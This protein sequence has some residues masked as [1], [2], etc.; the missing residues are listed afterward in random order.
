MVSAAATTS[1]SKAKTKGELAPP[2][3]QHQARCQGERRDHLEDD[4]GPAAPARRQH[5]VQ[6]DH[7]HH[8]DCRRGHRWL[9]RF[10]ANVLEM[11]IPTST[12]AM[13]THHTT[14]TT[15]SW[16][17]VIGSVPAGW[18]S[19]EALGAEAGLVQLAPSSE[20]RHQ[21]TQADECSKPAADEDEDQF[22]CH[23]PHSG[24]CLPLD[25]PAIAAARPRASLGAGARCAQ[26]Y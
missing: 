4:A 21:G 25:A 11:P 13:A 5:L 6:D 1:R 22:G 18:S 12:P 9:T 7:R 23:I 2:V 16:D 26:R 8:G 24:A 20:D 14:R 17:G 15:A 3:S 19:A 10:A